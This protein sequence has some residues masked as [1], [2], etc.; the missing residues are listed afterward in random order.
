VKKATVLVHDLRQVGVFAQTDLMGRSVKAQMKYANKI[1]A[2]Y[3]IVLGESE[4]QSGV[5]TIKNMQGGEPQT[6]KLDDLSP[7]LFK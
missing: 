3:C 7:E 2:A 6:V 4:L 5:A 1:G